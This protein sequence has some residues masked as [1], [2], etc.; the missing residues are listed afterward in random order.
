[1]IYALFVLT[2]ASCSSLVLTCLTR[3]FV[4]EFHCGQFA[5]L[6]HKPLQY[7][8]LGMG[9]TTLQQGN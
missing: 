9:C 5:R 1:L 7:A 4:I 8:A 2:T 6:S 3:V